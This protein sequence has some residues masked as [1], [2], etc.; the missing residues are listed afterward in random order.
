MAGTGADTYEAGVVMTGEPAGFKTIGADA[1]EGNIVSPIGVDF[2]VVVAAAACARA[3][4]GPSS[5][6]LMLVGA[7][8]SQ[9]ST[10][11]GETREG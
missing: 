9:A 2:E 5:V 6:P 8:A 11:G 10:K 3:T 7:K 1:R 4:E